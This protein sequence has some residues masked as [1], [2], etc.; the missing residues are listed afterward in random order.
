MW[1][2]EFWFGLDGDSSGQV[3]ELESEVG[4]EIGRGAGGVGTEGTEVG[5]TDCILWISFTV[6]SRILICSYRNFSLSI[7]S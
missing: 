6:L 1:A 2:G 5:T 7:I 4:N 3:W